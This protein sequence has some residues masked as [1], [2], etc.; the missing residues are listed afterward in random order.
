M[1]ASLNWIACSS[2]M[3]RTELLP[4]LGVGQGPL[5][6]AFGDAQSLGGDA[7]AAAVQGVHGDLE[8]LPFLPE[9]V[10][11]RDA[12]VVEG[13]GGGVTAADAQLV[14]VFQ[15]LDARRAAGRR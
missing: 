1:S 14:L 13:K 10:L 5:E 3:R 6:G 8:P 12:D 9:E 7:D 4:L 15:D 11:R 2:Q